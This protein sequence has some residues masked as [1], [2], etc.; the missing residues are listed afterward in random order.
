M[1]RDEAVAIIAQRLGNRTDLDSTI[2]AEMKLVQTDLEQGD[3]LPWFLISEHSQVTSTAD[4]ERVAVPSD[5]LRELDD[6]YN[7][8]WYVDSDGVRNPLV[9]TD[10]D[11]ALAKYGK[12][13]GTDAPEVYC[14]EGGYFR[15][16]PVNSS[17]LTLELSY[18]ATDQ[19]LST[20]IENQWLKYAPSLMINATGKVVAM[21]IGNEGAQA[22]F[23]QGENQARAQLIKNDAAR[24]EAGRNRNM[25]D[26]E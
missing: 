22:A 7:C 12:T 25:G 20:D 1:T 4:E 11:A 3:F 15:V 14:L 2:V 26:S 23:T 8:L 24:R 21:F 13:S 19:V 9:K 10:Y 18:Y 16:F 6:E 5:F 17:T